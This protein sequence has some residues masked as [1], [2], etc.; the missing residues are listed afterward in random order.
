MLCLVLMLH[1]CAE[2]CEHAP[3]PKQNTS[4]GFVVH[5]HHITLVR[6][7]LNAVEM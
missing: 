5:V 7:A 4:I 6:Q 1:F 2:H 3:M